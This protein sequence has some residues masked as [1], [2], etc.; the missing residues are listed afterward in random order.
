[1]FICAILMA[2][3]MNIALARPEAIA[4]LQESPDFAVM[5]S[6][7][8]AIIGFI[9]LAKRQGWGMIVAI[10]NG[11]WAGVLTI[12][13]SI[14]VYLAAVPIARNWVAIDDFADFTRLTSQAL[15]PL[16][17][18][19]TNAPLVVMILI[20]TAIVGVVTEAIHWSLVRALR[21]RAGTQE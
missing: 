9:N 16:I 18:Q 17:D 11:V 6:I 19:F 10:A 12:V 13:V 21:K 1:R 5:A 14:L 20:H 8:G 4:L 15:D 2:W 7:G 3:T